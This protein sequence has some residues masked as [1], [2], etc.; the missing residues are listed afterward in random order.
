[1]LAL[2][3]QF[4]VHCLCEIREKKIKEIKVVALVPK[5]ESAG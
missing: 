3:N 5:C 2:H 4:V 1:M